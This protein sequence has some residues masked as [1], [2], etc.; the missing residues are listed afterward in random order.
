MVLMFSSSL[1]ALETPA[2]SSLYPGG[3]QAG[4]LGVNP[5]TIMYP[6]NQWKSISFSALPLAE[7]LWSRELELNQHKQV[8]GTCACIHLGYTV[9]RKDASGVTVLLTRLNF[10][11]GPHGEVRFWPKPELVMYPLAVIREDKS[12]SVY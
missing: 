1:A 11:G 10:G 5:K 3:D 2:S 7:I 12:H 9:A 6:Q 8:Y 4:G